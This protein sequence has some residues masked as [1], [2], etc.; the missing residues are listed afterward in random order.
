MAAQESVKIAVAS[1]NRKTVTGHTG[2]CRKFW[3]YDVADGEIQQS[4]LLELP[5]EQSFHDS[6]PQHTHP[7]DD[8]D[9]LIGGGI[10]QG[11]QRRLQNM[12]IVPIVTDE[13]DLLQAVQSYIESGDTSDSVVS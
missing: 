11:L 8:V 2:R 4:H 10:G 1:Q 12:G 6:S 7:L 13:T 3:I 9:V 5:R